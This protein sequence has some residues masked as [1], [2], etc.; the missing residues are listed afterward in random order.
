MIEGHA[1]VHSDHTSEIEVL[2]TMYFVQCRKK[3]GCKLIRMQGFVKTHVMCLAI[4]LFT[5]VTAHLS[6]KT[7]HFLILK[8]ASI[9]FTTNFTT[10]NLNLRV[11]FRGLSSVHKASKH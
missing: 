8:Q 10:C 11:W 2:D 6:R 7:N 3:P 9:S 4:G 1:Y 5:L